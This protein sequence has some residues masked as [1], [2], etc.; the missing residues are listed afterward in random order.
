M[1]LIQCTPLRIWRIGYSYI[2]MIE[3]LSLKKKKIIVKR[4]K[5]K[6]KKKYL[7]IQT[8]LFIFNILTIFVYNSSFC[9]MISQ[10]LYVELNTYTWISI[11]NIHLWQEIIYNQ[12]ITDLKSSYVYKLLNFQSDEE[13][14]YNNTIFYT[15]IFKIDINE[16]LLYI[17]FHEK[18]LLLI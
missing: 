11:R 5:K 10:I 2:I 3:M 6:K 7:L 15:M 14:S 18:T 16:S 8:N 1:K 13:M 17:Q 12:K 4:I 9:Q